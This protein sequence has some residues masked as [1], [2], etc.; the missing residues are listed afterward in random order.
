ME[1]PIRGRRG[2]D[3]RRDGLRGQ[4]AGESK[5]ANIGISLPGTGEEP[6]CPVYIDGRH[7]TTLR[8]SHDELAETFRQLVDDYIDEKYAKKP[9]AS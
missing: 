8:G 3:R 9:A 5:A 2:D 7:A 4:R 1:D 6:T